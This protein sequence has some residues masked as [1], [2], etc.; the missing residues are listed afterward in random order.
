MAEEKTKRPYGRLDE[1]VL[2]EAL[3]Q[4]KTKVEAGKLAGSLAKRDE[5]IIHQV[6]YKINSNPQHKKTIIEKLEQRQHWILDSIKQDEILKAPL[7]QKSVSFGIFTDKAQLLKGDPTSRLE[8]MP[9]MVFK[10]DE[11]SFEPK[12][13]PESPE[14]TSTKK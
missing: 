8:I 5:N 12:S 14:Q 11:V 13:I 6:D 10:G 9:K 7:S 3:G 2:I 1:K 4:G